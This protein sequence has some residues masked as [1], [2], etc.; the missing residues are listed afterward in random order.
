MALDDALYTNRARAE[1]FG[2]VADDYDRYRTSYP[3]ALF[4]DLVGLGPKRVLDVACGTGKVAVPLLACGLAVLG[5]EPD[6]KMAEVARRH[7]IIVEVSDFESWDADGRRFDLIT[8]GQGWHWIDPD[9]G[10][11]KA[12]ELL[13]AGGTLALFWSYPELDTALQAAF[14][15]V[16]AKHAPDLP[17]DKRRHIEDSSHAETLR[18]GQLFE[19][20]E[21]RTYRWTRSFTTDEWIG[22]TATFSDHVRLPSEQRAALLAGLREVIDDRGGNVEAS[23]G[24][25]AIL[26]RVAE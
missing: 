13:N 12:A 20:V 7:G 3:D 4:A 2:S 18:A 19:S 9:K 16:Y 23:F 5:L 17:A 26:A 1:S 10:P 8:C 14:D 22:R 25:Y 24:T 6:P 15:E 11:A 21:T